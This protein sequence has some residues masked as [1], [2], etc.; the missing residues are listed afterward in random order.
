M[1]LALHLRVIWRYRRVAAIG[2]I[3]AIALTSLAAWKLKADTWKSNSTLFVTQAGFPW[4]RTITPYLPGDAVTGRPSIPTAD[5]QRLS[6]LAALYAQLAT[7]DPVAPWLKAVER[8][9]EKLTVTAVPAPQYSTP[10][11]LPLLQVEATAPSGKRAIA[12]ANRVADSLT[13]W[14]TEQQSSAGIPDSERVVVEPIS[15]ADTAKLVGGHGKTLPVVVF[16]TVLAA[17]FGLVFMLE[18]LRSTDPSA[19]EVDDSVARSDWAERLSA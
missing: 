3:L 14:L 5:S 18:N 12:L 1:D 15:R 4:G 17:T 2:L 10:A 16:L 8:T 9:H 7:S 19:G 11:I 13:S 6:S